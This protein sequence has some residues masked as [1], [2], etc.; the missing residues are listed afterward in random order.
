MVGTDFLVPRKQPTSDSYC[1]WFCRN[2]SYIW[3]V[4]MDQSKFIC[5]LIMFRSPANCPDS[6]SGRLRLLSKQSVPAT[7]HLQKVVIFSLLLWFADPVLG[8]TPL[9]SAHLVPWASSVVVV[10]TKWAGRISRERFDKSEAIAKKLSEMQSLRTRRQISQALVNPGSWN[11]SSVIR[12]KMAC[13][14]AGYNV[15][16]GMFVVAWTVMCLIFLF[17]FKLVTQHNKICLFSRR[18]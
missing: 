12:D 11:F 8:K 14:C 7:Y 6:S 2:S 3:R 1:S 13:K 10:V 9:N 16:I 15:T 17:F 4:P 18:T 5:A